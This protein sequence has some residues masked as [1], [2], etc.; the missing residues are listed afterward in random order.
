MFFEDYIQATLHSIAV[1]KDNKKLKSICIADIQMNTNTE[2]DTK[3]YS[4]L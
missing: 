3:E 2:Q 1:F 4:I